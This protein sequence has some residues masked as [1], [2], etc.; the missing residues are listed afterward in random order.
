MEDFEVPRHPKIPEMGDRTIPFGKKLYIE[1]SDFFDSEGAE[2]SASNGRAPKGFK[3]L[4]PGG[5]V[6]LKY[7]YVISCDEIKRDPDTNEPVEL[8]CSYHPETR[9]GVTPEGEK[10]V[11]GIIQWVESTSCIKARVNQYDR[12]FKEVEPGKDSGDYLMDLNPKSFEKFS[13][14]AIEPSVS[15]DAMAIMSEIRD[16]EE[17]GPA[18][19]NEDKLYPSQVAYQFERNGYFALDPS[20]MLCD[21]VFNRVVTLRDTWEGADGSGTKEGN[22][23]QRN[24]GNKK[25]QKPTQNKGGGGGAGVVEDVRRIALRAG[26]IL[27]AGPHPEAD[28]LIVCKVDCGDVDDESKEPKGPRTV[29]AGLAGKIPLDTLVGRKIACITNLKPARMRGIE[30]EAMLLAAASEDDEIV[31]LLSIPDSVP[32]GELLSFEGKDASDP[33]TMLKSKGALKVWDRVKA[34]LRA[35]GQGEATYVNEGET[36][37]IMSSAGPVS[38]DTLVDSIIQ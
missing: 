31:E 38:T 2:G 12:L 33:D 1:R 36:Y 22:D 29:V 5:K 18:D 3:R 32:N 8:V 34:G 19:D 35:N 15:L 27:E 28:S 21:L 10:R 30:S 11:P 20:S 25:E 26:T 4:V 16:Q 6:R 24:R 7:A 23:G 13:G 17:F 14:V 37:R 9:A